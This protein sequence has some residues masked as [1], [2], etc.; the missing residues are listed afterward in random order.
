MGRIGGIPESFAHFVK[1]GAW[2]GP[3]AIVHPPVLPRASHLATNTLRIS[4]HPEGGLKVGDAHIGTPRNPLGAKDLPALHAVLTQ[5][6]PST[7]NKTAE[8]RITTS[9]GRTVHV[10]GGSSSPWAHMQVST[11]QENLTRGFPV[12][13]ENKWLKPA[14][15]DTYKFIFPIRDGQILHSVFVNPDAASALKTTLRVANYHQANFVFPMLTRPQAGGNSP[16]MIP[17][18]FN[19]RTAVQKK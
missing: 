13:P 12:S 10:S 11:L 15:H 5:K 14:G 4:T 3:N 7:N 6:S 2:D 9:W 1:G 19:W 16:S 17:A 8:L 18:N